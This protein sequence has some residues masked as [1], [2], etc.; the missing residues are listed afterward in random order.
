MG[1][2]ASG[3]GQNEPPATAQRAEKAGARVAVAG[4]ALSRGALRSRGFERGAMPESLP[5]LLL[6]R[7]PSRAGLA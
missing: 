2:S 7:T 5:K 3:R 1:G 4:V 6:K